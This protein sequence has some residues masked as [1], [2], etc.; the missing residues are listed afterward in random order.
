MAV[1]H[2][3]AVN[4]FYEDHAQG[5]GNS[6]SSHRYGIIGRHLEGEMEG[7]QVFAGVVGRIG[8]LRDAE[9]V[10]PRFVALVDAG[11]EIDEMPAGLASRLHDQLDIALA[12]ESAGIADVIVVVD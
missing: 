3:L 8:E 4:A 9:I 6:L 12:V 2:G 10:R 11:I 7:G 1:G 5:S